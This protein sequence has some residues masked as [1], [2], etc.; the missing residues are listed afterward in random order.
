[1]TVIVL[2]FDPDGIVPPR[3]FFTR[4]DTMLRMDRFNFGLGVCNFVEEYI[5]LTLVNSVLLGMDHFNSGPGVR[6][7]TQTHLLKPPELTRKLPLDGGGIH[8]GACLCGP[9][10]DG[11]RTAGPR[12]VRFGFL[13]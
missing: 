2:P 8:T 7:L 13:A 6:N 10:A 3:A 9:N 11:N 12:F 4:V 1:M 5:S